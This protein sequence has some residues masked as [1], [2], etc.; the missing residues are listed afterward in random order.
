MAPP[1]GG[2]FHWLQSMTR[3]FAD[4][5]TVRHG[6]V[7]ISY[8]VAGP[9]AD[10]T[11]TLCLIASTGRGPEDFAHLAEELAMGGLRVV[12][13][14]PRGT[15]HSR[16]PVDQVDFHDLAKDAAAALAAEAGAGRAFIV[17]HAYGCWIART[18]A[19][20]LPHLVD[21]VILMAAGSGKWPEELSRAIEIAMSQDAPE[22]D[23][24]A[25]LKLA[26][27]AEGQD[28]RTWLDGWNP[29]L[30]EMQRAARARTGRDS[31][32][33]SGSA[34]MLDI[35]GL[36]DPFRP[37]GEL[38]FYVREFAPRVD[39]RTVDGASHAL[40]DEKPVEVAKLILDWLKLRG[41]LAK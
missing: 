25:A 27:F 40:P 35:V 23:R 30:V 12:L 14:W 32:W 33:P 39:L 11:P 24:I 13:P 3:I 34:P 28:P 26:F 7:K 2:P 5:R 9:S 22:A 8:A 36:Q 41:A 19:Q 15:G 17:G 10:E 18:M 37:V 20:D 38:D 6:R 16:G 21:G 4:V 31:W 1:C 29:K